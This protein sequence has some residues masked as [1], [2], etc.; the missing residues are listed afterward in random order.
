MK[1]EEKQTHIK[2]YVVRGGRF[3]KGQQSAYERLKDR[4]LINAAA[5]GGIN[6][7]DTLN[8]HMLFG[9]SG[10]VIAEI[11]FGSGSATAL[12][13]EKQRAVNYVGI[14]VYRPGIGNLLKLIEEKQL[15]NIRIYEGDAFTLFRDNISE[16]SLRGV[17]LFFPDPWPKKRHHKRR[18]VQPGFSEILQRSLEKDGYVYFVTDWENYGEHARF[19]FDGTEGLENMFEGYAPPQSWRPVTRFHRKGEARDHKIYELYYVKR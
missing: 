11:G 14:E 8:F 15:S 2:S 10:P 7:D 1:H 4:F 17:H 9:N 3:S 18:L 16:A 5:A 12:I 6:P 13:A 19:V